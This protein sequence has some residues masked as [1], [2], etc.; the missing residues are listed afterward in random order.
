M[1][2]DHL[3]A[4]ALKDRGAYDLIKK[5]GNIPSYGKLEEML[6]E[7]INQFY[8]RDPS[9]TTASPEIILDILGET[10]R[11]DKH[12]KQ[13]KDL[14]QAA[15]Q[16]DV[17]LSTDNVKIALLNAH[18]KKVKDKLAVALLN[19]DAKEEAALMDQ[20]KD[21]RTLD[22]VEALDRLGLEEYPIESVDELILKA[23]DNTNIMKVYPKSLG[24]R[25]G[26]GLKPGHHAVI[27]AR[28]NMG[29]SM[30]AVT[31]GCGF[32]NGG[33]KVLV[34][35]NEEPAGDYWLRFIQAL[36]GKTKGEVLGNY[37]ESKT[38]ALKRGLNNITI[39]SAAPG[40]KR[41]VDGLMDKYKP[42]VLIIDQLRNLDVGKAESRTNQLE[43][44]AIYARNTAI[45]YHCAVISI[46]QA[47]DSATGKQILDMNDIDGSKTGI[48]A[49]ADL[50]IGIGADAQAEAEGYRIITLCKNKLTAQHEH[51]PVK[52]II[53]LS[54]YTDA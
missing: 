51:W 50:M 30:L 14:L 18:I 29:K 24:D 42:N 27:F 38:L 7:A 5:Y 9:S 33:W 40:T 13:F 6:F 22:T 26:G 19:N 32:A 2:I 12:L 23:Y 52:A 28:P 41:Q 10:V 34:L 48:P 3:R 4:A 37:H 1:N 53:P 47:G 45:R 11:N 20:L 16:L 17:D 39:V 31:M 35:G 44:A 25:I 8:Y 54:K 49:T 21:L 43:A 46:T 36:S 15:H